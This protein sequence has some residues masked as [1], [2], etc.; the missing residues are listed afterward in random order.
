MMTRVDQ[1]IHA[2]RERK[3]ARIADKLRQMPAAVEYFLR[4][5]AAIT[6]EQWDRAMKRVGEKGASEE[7]RAMVMRILR[8]GH[9]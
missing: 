7:T 3:A 1:I 4:N 6:P 9:L 5:E 2:N 8:E